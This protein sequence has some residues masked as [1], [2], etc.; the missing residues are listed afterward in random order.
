[1]ASGLLAVFSL[2][3]T[4]AQIYNRKQPHNYLHRYPCLKLL[5]RTMHHSCHNGEWTLGRLPLAPFPTIGHSPHA[6][7]RAKYVTGPSWYTKK[8]NNQRISGVA[9]PLWLASPRL[10]VLE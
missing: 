6:G 2:P 10:L 9:R 5:L 8:D 4:K 7:L 3:P 1:M